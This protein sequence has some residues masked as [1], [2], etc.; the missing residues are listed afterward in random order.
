MVENQ[1]ISTLNLCPRIL[2]FIF[3]FKALSLAI[4]YLIRHGLHQRNLTPFLL[5]K[6]FFGYSNLQL[7]QIIFFIYEGPLALYLFTLARSFAQFQLL[8]RSL[9]RSRKRFRI[10]YLLWIMNE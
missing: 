9:S 6:N 3:F 2:L 5:I 1:R 4:T 7:A 8:S 10:Q